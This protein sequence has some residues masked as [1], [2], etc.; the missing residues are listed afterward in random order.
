MYIIAHTDCCCVFFCLCFQFLLR[1]VGNL[2]DI[3]LGRLQGCK[4]P[5]GRGSDG[6]QIK[7]G[8]VR[9]QRGPADP[10]GRAEISIQRAPVC[11]CAMRCVCCFP[12][13]AGGPVPKPIAARELLTQLRRLVGGAM[14]TKKCPIHTENFHSTKLLKNSPLACG[15]RGLRP[16]IYINSLS[17]P[18][19]RLHGLKSRCVVYFRSSFRKSSPPSTEKFRAR[20]RRRHRQ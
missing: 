8:S 1:S 11:A 4:G 7:S 6:T 2:C 3:R 19:S 18:T 10:N 5:R 20:R 17:I 15:R 12:M 16:G 14:K 13:V 9:Q